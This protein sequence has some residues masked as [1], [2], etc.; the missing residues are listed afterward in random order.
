MGQ[1]LEAAFAE[2]FLRDLRVRLLPRDAFEARSLSRVTTRR[3][4]HLIQFHGAGLARLGTTAA[5]AHGPYELSRPWARA[6]W[7]HPSQ[8]DGLS[9]RPRHDDDQLAVALFDRAADAIAA[10]GAPLLVS[11]LPELPDLLRRYDIGLVE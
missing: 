3:A 9:Y 6:C 8:Q 11:S 2:V 10:P 1:T 7:E 4:V 5:M